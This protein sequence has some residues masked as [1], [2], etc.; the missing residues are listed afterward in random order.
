MACVSAGLKY[1][2]PETMTFSLIQNG[3]LF[4]K[5]HRDIFLDLGYGMH[6]FNCV[7]KKK[8]QHRNFVKT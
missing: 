1:F 7:W 3:I 5:L 2:T 6:N 4:V 8:H